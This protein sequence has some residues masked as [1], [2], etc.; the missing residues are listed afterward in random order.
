MYSLFGLFVVLCLSFWSP[1]VTIRWLG[2]R[3]TSQHTWDKKDC[4]RI[5]GFSG[6]QYKIC[7]RNLP[8]MLYVTAA[9]E[10]TREECQ[11]QFQNKR[12]N[13]STIVKAPQFLPDLKRG[14]PEAAFVYALSAAALTY[15]ITQ[16]CGMKRLKPCKCGTNPK[17]KHPDGEWGGCHDNIARGMRFSK[18]FTD[19]VEAQR[20]RKHK[21]MAVALMNLHNN[22]VGRKAVHS[23]LE[24]HCR[25]HGVSGGC[26]AK[27]C[28]RRLGDFR[29]VAD[30]LK[31]RYAR[32]VYVE[33]KTKS[34]R[35]ARVLKSKRG[36]RRYTSSDLV[37]L[38]G[39]PN[40]CH[41]NRKR[42]TAGTHGRLCDPTKRRGEGSCAYLCC[43]R[44]HRT[45]EVVH[46]ERCECKYIWCCYVKCQTCRKRVRESRCL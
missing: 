17:F 18:D 42:G 9:V 29:L 41:K 31:N 25:C 38:Q 3:H 30:L 21:S 40:Y 37:A 28:I 16:A 14:T 8:A 19:A 13:C 22:G 1:V 11:H 33:S 4:N 35:K 7:R 36:R 15:S 20:M 34:K 6:K 5:H 23:R 2:I 26:T 45:E 43:G 39:S 44:G 24:F 12:W 27:T 46:E 32:I 10:M